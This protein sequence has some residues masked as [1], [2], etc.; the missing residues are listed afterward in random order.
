MYADTFVIY[1]TKLLHLEKEKGIAS[2]TSV[3]VDLESSVIFLGT[4]NHKK[5]LEKCIYILMSIIM[6]ILMYL[7]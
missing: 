2:G 6:S 5:K 4:E 1:E 7:I 3:S